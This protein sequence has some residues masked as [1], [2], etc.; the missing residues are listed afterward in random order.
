M[1]NRTGESSDFVE[2]YLAD[3]N[4][5]DLWEETNNS[6]RIPAYHTSEG[7][8]IA[9]RTIEEI[10]TAYASYGFESYGRSTV[11][12]ESRIADLKPLKKGTKVIFVD[13]SFVNV[14]KSV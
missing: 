6:A 10:S 7:S 13:N 4:Y 5:I 11:I 3:V 12:N 2:F 8:F 14:R 9:L 1:H